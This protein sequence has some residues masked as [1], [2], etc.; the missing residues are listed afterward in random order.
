MNWV[1]TMKID[2]AH[3]DWMKLTSRGVPGQRLLDAGALHCYFG[4]NDRSQA[5]FLV[6]SD[7]RSEAPKLAE[8]VRV[9]HGRR[10]D[11]K[12]TVVLTLADQAY[13]DAFIGMCLEVSRR[14]SL[15]PDEASALRIFDT[16][17]HQWRHLLSLKGARRLSDAEIRGL[18][19]ELKFLVEKAA[20]YGPRRA[21]ESWV[22]PHGAPQDFRFENGKLFEL[23]SIR[24]GAISIH[25]SSVEQLDAAPEDELVLIAKVVNDVPTGMSDLTLASLVGEIR[26][27]L[28]H[29]GDG[30]DLFSQKLALLQLDET[31]P[32]YSEKCFEF[33]AMQA[34]SVLTDFPRIRQSEVPLGVERIK[35][36]LR[37]SALESFKLDLPTITSGEHR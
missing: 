28:S 4:V 20:E 5:V 8:L 26:S 30:L 9:E 18:A 2:A 16:T 27:I 13:G 35:Y 22:G 11:G 23:K 31:D 33:G 37:I 25:I 17:I 29:D 12:W 15:A 3:D 34:F 19:A 14:A 10:P 6:V 36:Q 21:L 32:Y 1:I 24:S 7:V